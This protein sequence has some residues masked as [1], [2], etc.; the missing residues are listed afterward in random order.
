MIKV[1]AKSIREYKKYTL[2]APLFMAG[3]CLFECLIPF[4]MSKLID[5]LEN[6]QMAMVYQYGGILLVMAMCSLFCGCM[7]ARNAATAGCGFAKNLR[8]DMFYKIQE[9]AFG[10]VDKFSSS[11]LVT[12]MTTDVTNVQNAFGMF[13]RMAFRVPF[14]FIF[15]IIMGCNINVKLTMIFVCIMPFLVFAIIMI[16]KKVMAIFKRIFKKYDALNNSVQEN[17]NGIRVVKAFVKEDFEIEKFHSAS[18]EVRDDFIYAEKNMA[19]FHPIMML[20]M[21][22]GMLLVCYFGA[23]VIVTTSGSELSTGQLSSLMSYGVQILSGLMMFAMIFV[24]ATIAGEAANRIAEVLVYKPT[25]VSKED[26]IKEVKDGSIEFENVNFRYEKARKNAL[27]NINLSIKPGQTIGIIG[28]TGSSKSTLIQLISRLYDVT[29]GSVKVGGVDVRDYDLTA[30]RDQVAVVLQK[31]VLFAGTIK[32]NMRWGNENATDEEIMAA[33]KDACAHEFIETF[34]DGYDTMIEQGGSNVSGGQKQ[35]LCIARALLKKPKILILD[36]STSAVDTRTD[37]LIRQTFK[38]KIPDT[39]K[40]IIAQRVSSVQDADRILVMEK[41]SIV[42]EG[43]AA[44]LIAKGGIYAE[45]HQHQ[46]Q[47]R[48]AS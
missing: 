17:I 25:L 24:M 27:N 18:A 44:E 15:S 47:G 9:F 3:E 38:D 13:I 31:N 40:I 35:R 28:G 10:D 39:T 42:E 16:A 46:T 48:E 4:V 29:E 7:S 5:S 45:I 22:V 41:G 20:C 11:S 6:T 23:K 36:D 32:E 2:A 43:T 8:H 26:G 1:L 34:P 30:L 37:A 14:L 21:N 19:L 12:R 33:C